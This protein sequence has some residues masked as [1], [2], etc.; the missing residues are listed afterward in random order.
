[1]ATLP[2]TNQ[3]IPPPKLTN[4]KPEE[5]D[6]RRPPA[7]VKDGLDNDSDD[8]PKM[9]NTVVKMEDAFDS[10]PTIRKIGLANGAINK[11][12]PTVSVYPGGGA[13]KPPVGGGVIIKKENALLAGLVPRSGPRSG[14]KEASGKRKGKTSAPGA[15]VLGWGEAGGSS[16]E[17]EDEDGEGKGEEMPE[18]DDVRRGLGCVLTCHA[19]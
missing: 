6:V 12:K 14:K 13:V 1:M 4:L 19:E 16:E 7:D 2:S 11:P 18:D 8:P 10:V 5:L 15:H 9:T 3:A 17:E